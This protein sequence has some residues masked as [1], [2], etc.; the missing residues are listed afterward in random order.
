MEVVMR[1]EIKF[2]LE[3][4][5]RELELNFEKQQSGEVVGRE[6]QLWYRL[7]SARDIIVSMH[8]DL[9]RMLG[10]VEDGFGKK[11]EYEKQFS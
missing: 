8:Y 2:Q 7:R 4:I 9:E 6:L 10:N 5:D 11:R 1:K 3:L